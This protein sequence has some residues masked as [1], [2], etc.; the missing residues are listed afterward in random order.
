MLPR[1]LAVLIFAAGSALA[2]PVSYATFLN[3]EGVQ[4][5]F[6]S[7]SDTRVQPGPGS[8]VTAQADL[9][10]G[11]LRIRTVRTSASGG[12][13]AQALFYDTITFDGS[14]FEGVFGASYNLN[15][16]ATYEGTFTATGTI[17]SAGVG[18][19][20]HVYS[21]DTVID[22]GVFTDV[23][24]LTNF[25]FIGGPAPVCANGVNGPDLVTHRGFFQFQV[26]CSVTVT[27]LNPTVKILMNLPGFIN[28]GAATW[29]LNMMNTATLDLGDLGGRVVR[30]ASGVLPGTL[31]EDVPEPSTMGLAALALAGFWL[32]TKRSGMTE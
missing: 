12:L 16:T 19:R 11:A 15:L 22:S 1:Q 8:E 28:A 2:G 31:V 18:G 26:S 17:D 9:S 32:R 25:M 6:A 29:D 3:A 7:P 14:A 30:S 5:Q 10:Q 13:G 27:A 23:T 4:S 21:G 24:S 20:I